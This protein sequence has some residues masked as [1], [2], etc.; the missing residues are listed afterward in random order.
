MVREFTFNAFKASAID[1]FLKSTS[2]P[3]GAFATT[4]S[5]TSTL[6]SG[7]SPFG[8]S[9]TTAEFVVF[10][11]T[12]LPAIALISQTKGVKLELAL[13]CTSTTNVSYVPFAF[14]PA[15]SG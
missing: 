5:S 13:C 7:D 9:S 14:E 3:S 1:S 11:G 2:S 10:V 4:A 8:L 15:L 12:L 6:V